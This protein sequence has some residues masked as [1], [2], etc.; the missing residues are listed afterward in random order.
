MS[1]SR[2]K[3]AKSRARKERRGR[4]KVMGLA[5]ATVP[6]PAA[7]AP[8]DPSPASAASLPLQSGETTLPASPGYK[9]LPDDSKV[10]K[11]VMHIIAMRLAGIEETEIAKSLGIAR[12]TI[13][14]YIYL[15]G[16]NGWLTAQDVPDPKD[17]L[18]YQLVHKVMDNLEE[19]LDDDARHETSGIKVRHAVALKIA[20]GTVFK[21]FDQAVIQPHQ[22]NTVVAIRIEMPPGEPQQV[23]EGTLGGVSNYIDTETVEGE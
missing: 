8:P 10:R 16:K 2:K 7:V 6:V 20:E 14:H 21:K 18:E 23:R 12:S 4:P 9:V 17:R 22:K 5:P 13:S 15:A 1:T 19:A 11:T 3:S